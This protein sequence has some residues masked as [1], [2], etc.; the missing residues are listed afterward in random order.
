MIVRDPY[1]DDSGCRFYQVAQVEAAIA[2]KETPLDDEVYEIA[3]AP[4]W[5]HLIANAGVSPVKW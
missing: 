3:H 5:R 4:F 1:E 2:E